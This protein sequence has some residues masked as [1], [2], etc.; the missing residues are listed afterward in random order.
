M[1]AP[2]PV[3]KEIFHVIMVK[4]SRYDETGYVVQWIFQPVP[5]NSLACVNGLLQDCVDRK[6][7]GEDVDIRLHPID[8]CNQRVDIDG[9]LA[10]IERDGGRG[11]LAMVG[12]QSNQFPRTMDISRRFIEAGLPVC[13]GGFHVSGCIS[14][15]PEMPD[16]LKEAQALGISF[17]CGEAEG[18]RMEIVLKDAYDGELKPI[19]NFMKDLPPVEDEPVPFLPAD[20]VRGTFGDYTSFDIGRGCPYQCSFCT[21]INVHGRKSRFRSPDDLE[22]VVRAN[23]A[24][25]VYKYF[26]TDDNMARNKNWEPLFDRLIKLRKEEGFPFRLII[27]VDTQCHLIPNF[28]EKAVAAGVKQ[29][30]IGLENINPD[31]LVAAKKHQNKITEYRRMMQAW[32]KYNVILYAG[33]IIGFPH[34]TKASVIRDVEIIKRELPVDMVWFSYLTPLPGSEDHRKLYD[35][36]EWMDPDMS[37]YNLNHRVAHH[38]VMSDQ[39]WEEAYRAAWETYYEYGHIRTIIR[40]AYSFGGRRRKATLQRLM[41]YRLFPIHWRTQP[42]EGGYFPLRYRK[43][44]A[45]WMKREGVIAFYARYGWDLLRYHA[46]MLTTMARIRLIY[47]SI[48]LD[49]KHREYQDIATTPPSDE[50]LGEL[51]LYTSSEGAVKA[52]ERITKYAAARDATGDDEHPAPEADN[53]PGE[54][55]DADFRHDHSRKRFGDVM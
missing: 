45:S 37:K 8:E 11:M 10:M 19:Y 29:V 28:I 42:L 13:I 43:D 44:R 35:K 48:L 41:W 49:P 40:R 20:R 47:W 34:D 24:Q 52:V 38:P 12:V 26:I 31:N 1:L 4:P 55:V 9:L 16:D 2:S 51:G 30:F 32:K 39:E 25:G 46:F 33:Y 7:L 18:G 23:A 53:Q 21:I 17:F 22:K 27:Q 50:E 14:M 15:L 6:V 36:G 54:R 5:A 3:E